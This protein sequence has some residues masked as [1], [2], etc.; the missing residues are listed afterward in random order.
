[1]L[2]NNKYVITC[3]LKKLQL[4]D[5]LRGICDLIGWK[6]HLVSIILKANLRRAQVQINSLGRPQSFQT[7][8]GL[9]DLITIWQIA[10]FRLESKSLEQLYHETLPINPN[11][12]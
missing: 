6:R 4:S 5:R 11:A 8:D 9:I 1:M 3:I 10:L 2:R 7:G 12:S